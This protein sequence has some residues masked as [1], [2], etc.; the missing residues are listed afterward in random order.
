[1]STPH[2]R[3]GHVSGVVESSIWG[4]CGAPKLWEAARPGQQALPAAPTQDFIVQ[5]PLPPGEGAALSSPFPA[6]VALVQGKVCA[7]EGGGAWQA[8]KEMSLGCSKSPWDWSA[9]SPSLL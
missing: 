1:M 7:L 2:W 4:G 3:T 9:S 8:G 6:L 5:R